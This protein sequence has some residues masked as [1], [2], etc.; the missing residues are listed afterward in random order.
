MPRF[1]GANVEALTIASVRV[2]P[3][4]TYNHIDFGHFLA[5]EIHDATV[6]CLT[7]LLYIAAGY[8]CGLKK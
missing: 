7:K 1:E 4:F 8:L 3:E 6:N 5:V 2:P